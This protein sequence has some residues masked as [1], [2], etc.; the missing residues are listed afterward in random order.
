[1]LSWERRS[2]EDHCRSSFRSSRVTA[3]ESS[4]VGKHLRHDGQRVPRRSA[5]IRGEV[6]A[7]SRQDSRLRPSHVRSYTLRALLEENASWSMGC[8]GRSVLF[9]PFLSQVCWL[10]PY[11]TD[12]REARFQCTQRAQRHQSLSVVR[13]PICDLGCPRLCQFCR[14]A[15]KSGTRI[16]ILEA[17]QR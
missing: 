3:N 2:H 7:R 15:E 5:N 17:A 1:M 9:I 12:R 16:P 4:S 11:V 10:T 8:E 14:L 6:R 13:L